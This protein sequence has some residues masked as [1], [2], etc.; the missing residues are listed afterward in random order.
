MPKQKLH[1]PHLGLSD[2]ESYKFRDSLSK[3]ADILLKADVPAA[4]IRD[5][6]GA[7]TDQFIQDAAAHDAEKVCDFL[8]AFQSGKLPNGNEKIK[9]VLMTSDYPELFYSAT[10][11]LLKSRI[12]PQAVVS[13]NLFQSI[14]YSGN[15]TTLTIR[16]IGGVKFEEIAEGG[17]YPETSTGVADQTY[18]IHFEIKKYG[19]K[20]AA[21][22]ELIDSDNWGIFAATMAQLGDE[23][24]MLRE[25]ICIGRLNNDAG[26]VLMDNANPS[27]TP[28]GTPTG[29]GIDG[30]QNGA[31]GVDDIMEIMAY[32]QQRGY[33]IDTVLIH[34]FA[35]MAWCRDPEIREAIF[36]SSLANPVG[37]PAQGFG[38]PF[39][40]LGPNYSSFGGAGPVGAASA[41]AALSAGNATLDPIFKKLGISNYAF[42]N[43][44]PFGATFYTNP[45]YT[46]WPLKIIVSPLVPFYKI[47][48]ALS[49]GKY[50]C[51]II[52]ADSRKCGLILER[53]APAMEQWS[54]IEKEIEYMKV[55]T[56]FGVAFQDQG[57]AIAIAKNVI[58]DRTYAFDNVNSVTLS[59]LNR[60]TALL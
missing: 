59:N 23:I 18:R 40:G 46:A 33:H 57:R 55:R 43:L 17:T 6:D 22:R 7:Y 35:Y 26:Y 31:L 32:M 52:F 15:A 10:Q 41:D 58:I 44:T 30:K 2:L 11:I 50:A 42:P 12:Y 3:K 29:R 9:D 5:A 14:P 38:S 16:S 27:A 8:H 51:N 34:P 49:T 60:T 24:A 1:N 19:A 28:L 36:G 56:R 45:K 4:D 53:E 21:T 20:L 37:S 39:G 48:G 47:T 13:Q 25:K 54:D